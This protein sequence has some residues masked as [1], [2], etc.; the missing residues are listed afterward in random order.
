M[1]DNTIKTDQ[2][3]QVYE[4]DIYIWVDNYIN[5]LEDPDLIYTNKG[6]FS[7]M[8]N[9]IYKNYIQY[10]LNNNIYHNNNIR[11]NNIELLDNLFSIYTNLVYKYKTPKRLTL[12]E[13]SI[14]TGIGKDTLYN[15]LYGNTKE[16]NPKYKETVKKWYTICENSLINDTDTVK[17]IFLLK[18]VHG[19][20]DNIAVKPDTS[21]TVQTIQELPQ[22]SNIP[23]LI[24]QNNEN[25]TPVIDANKA[26]DTLK[27]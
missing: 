26:A 27:T 16:L 25:N 17:S 9:Y 4:S 1:S 5:S 19:Y 21:Q 6:L 11:Y 8:I 13:F 23:G 2:N 7:D 15:W 22:F 12:L 18:S 14:F 3:I 10:L 20:N 24:V